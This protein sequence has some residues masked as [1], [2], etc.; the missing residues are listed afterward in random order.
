ML[1]KANKS[2]SIIPRVLR[3][4]ISSKK[5]L[6]NDYPPLRISDITDAILCISKVGLSQKIFPIKPSFSS[7]S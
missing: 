5:K 3:I 2:T 6:A 4:K 7:I 1:R